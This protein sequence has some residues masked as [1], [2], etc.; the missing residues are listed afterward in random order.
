MAEEIVSQPSPVV[1]TPPAQVVTETPVTAPVETSVVAPVETL[2]GTE[3]VEVKTE[4]EK[5]VETAPVEKTAET[6][7]TEEAVK[8]PAKAEE[9]KDGE[10][11]EAEKT[12]EAK[13]EE[14]KPEESV[15]PTYEPLVLPEGAKL[16]PER[17]V[18]IDS[19]FGNFEKISKADHA[20]VQKF[21]QAMFDYGTAAIKDAMAEVKTSAD[22]YWA[23]KMEAERKE[24]ENDPEI[25]GNRRDTTLAAAN[26]FIR[27]HGGTPE[28]QKA[29]R[30]LL[31]ERKLAN[32]PIMI[33]ALANANLARAEGR[34][35]PAVTPPAPK[36]GKMQK[37]YGKK[38]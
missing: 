1:E 28:Q 2:L 12:D 3:S 37:M 4:V 8:E 6:P 27:T 7:K 23:D 30:S 16:T 21:R 33:R 19:M 24:F 20:E 22:K 5:S 11:T 38:K 31:E 26:Q 9:K 13:T 17:I 36:M 25:G 18:E 14:K 10:K 34:P 32:N 35:L 29:F 15:L